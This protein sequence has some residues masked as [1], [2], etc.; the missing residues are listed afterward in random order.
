MNINDLNDI[1]LRKCAFCN[2]KMI[3]KTR[4]ADDYSLY[5]QIKCSGND[6]LNH[7]DYFPISYVNGIEEINEDEVNQLINYYNLDEKLIKN[8]K[9]WK[10]YIKK[11]QLTNN[12]LRG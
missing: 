8:E 9:E 11:Y 7:T 6:C 1:E 12:K 2:S 3:F 5:L 10:E 4:L